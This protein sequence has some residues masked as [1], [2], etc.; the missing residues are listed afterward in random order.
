LQFSREHARTILAFGWP[1]LVSGTLMFGVYQGDRWL[2]GSFYSMEV[3]GAYSVAAL[4]TLVPGYMFTQVLTSVMLPLLSRTQET[5]ESFTTRYKL[6]MQAICVCASMYAIL[7]ILG[8]DSIVVACF[9]KKYAG[10]A[11]VL[12]WLAVGNAFR[13]LRLG[14]VLITLARGDSRT[15]MIASC[16]R[17]VGLIPAFYAASYKMELWVVAA[18]CVAGEVL[19]FCY[20]FYAGAKHH[21]IA[22]SLSA[23]PVGLGCVAILLSASFVL[24]FRQNSLLVTILVI[25]VGA[26]I[27]LATML[28]AFDELRNKLLVLV[29][30]VAARLTSM[31][32]SDAV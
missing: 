24:M 3:L 28:F 15:S 6:C 7:L 21:K 2:V 25:V 8:G 31:L 1:L 4:L 11:A 18:C 27:S 26:G 17:A 30:G 14:P 32:A 19:A 13:M 10:T 20:V 16:L 23:K 5:P 9:S 29:R 22:P 12:S